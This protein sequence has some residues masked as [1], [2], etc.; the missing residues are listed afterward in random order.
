MQKGAASM[1]RIKLFFHCLFRKILKNLFLYATLMYPLDFEI[2]FP[3]PNT[4]LCCF[5]PSFSRITG[6][7]LASSAHDLIF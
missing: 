3:Q 7:K 5:C 6:F 4:L 2:L 1:F